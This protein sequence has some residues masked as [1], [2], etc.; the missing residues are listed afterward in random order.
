MGT[1]NEEVRKEPW[2]FPMVCYSASSLTFDF[3]GLFFLTVEEEEE[4]LLPNTP[5][6][7]PPLSLLSPVASHSLLHGHTA[8]CQTQL[9]RFWPDSGPACAFS[10]SIKDHWICACLGL[11]I[12][13]RLSS[14]FCSHPKQTQNGQPLPPSLSHQPWTGGHLRGWIIL[15]PPRELEFVPSYVQK[16]GPRILKTTLDFFKCPV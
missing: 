11:E 12:W 1:F 8:G 2:A 13:A 5:H 14:V 7:I 15:R 16:R 6:S 9:R 10:P 4:I 3:D